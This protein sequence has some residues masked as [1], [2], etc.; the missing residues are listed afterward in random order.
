[1]K[2]VAFETSICFPQRDGLSPVLITC[3]LAAALKS[4]REISTRPNPPVA[5][6]G[7]PL[8][9][10]YADDVDFLDEEKKPLDELLPIA[11]SKLKIEN[12]FMNESKTEFTHMYLSTKHETKEND[13]P[14]RG[15]EPWR[16]SKILGSL[17]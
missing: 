8:E 6:L 5:I 1:V 15:G 14:L 12:L 7:M 4:V 9:M 2:S 3:Y 17:P 16:K 10:E 13:D 11:A